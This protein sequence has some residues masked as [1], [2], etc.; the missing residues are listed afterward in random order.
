MHLNLL[1]CVPKVRNT[2]PIFR[3]VN[4]ELVFRRAQTQYLRKM[5]YLAVTSVQKTLG[6][7]WITLNLAL[8][9][10]RLTALNNTFAFPYA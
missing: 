6:E 4:Y 7:V 9:P 5:P 1:V 3:L 8:M 10:V 2:N